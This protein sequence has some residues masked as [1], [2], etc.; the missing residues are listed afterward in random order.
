MK[1][2]LSQYLPPDAVDFCCSAYRLCQTWD[3]LIDTGSAEASE[4][5]AAFQDAILEWQRNSF[6]LTHHH[7]LT[8]LL[9]SAILQWHAANAIEAALLRRLSQTG[10]KGK[11]PEKKE[12][13]RSVWRARELCVCVQGT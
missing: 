7:A 6:Y 8:A 13:R 4:I 11:T 10:R 1:E 5:N 9:G 2:E 3:D 12:P